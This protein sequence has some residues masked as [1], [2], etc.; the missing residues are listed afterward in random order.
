M[1]VPW[2][3][4]AP[5]EAF[6]LCAFRSPATMNLA[7]Q[8]EL[9]LAAGQAGFGDRVLGIYC[10]RRHCLQGRVE[11][12]DGERGSDLR[13][14]GQGRFWVA[15]AAERMPLG[16]HLQCTARGT[17]GR[18][19]MAAEGEA[20][21]AWHGCSSDAGLGLRGRAGRGS[22]GRPGHRWSPAP[23]PPAG[24]GC[25]RLPTVSA[26]ARSPSAGRR[27]LRGCFSGL[28]DQRRRTGDLPALEPPTALASAITRL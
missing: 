21:R 16:A 10:F 6:I 7:Q 19:H 13:G 18:G 14:E 24:R 4:D 12:R 5:C 28:A 11:A 1:A 17:P 27:W 3:L 25:S 22:G 26:S 8:P 2:L 23:G 9:S 15:A 20:G